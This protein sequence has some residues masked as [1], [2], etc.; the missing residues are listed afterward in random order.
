MLAVRL[1]LGPAAVKSLGRMQR[2]MAESIMGRLEAVAARPFGQHANAKRLVGVN[3]GF[4]LRVGDW[5]ALYRIDRETDTVFV[6][7]VV[8]RGEA[9]R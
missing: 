2:K 5:R 6:E 1:L 3:D 4:R 7:D 9:Y 8:T